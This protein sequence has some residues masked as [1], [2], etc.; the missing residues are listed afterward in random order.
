MS[1]VIP[2]AISCRTVSR[3]FVMVLNGAS[4]LPFP[5]ESLPVGDTK[6]TVFVEEVE[7]VVLGADSC[8]AN[9]KNDEM[10]KWKHIHAAI[11]LKVSLF[12]FDI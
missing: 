11:S 8:A 3:A 1:E 6:K 7:L 10:N 9:V 4:M 5:L 12:V 2:F